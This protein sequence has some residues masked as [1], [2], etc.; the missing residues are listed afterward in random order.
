MRYLFPRAAGYSVA[1]SGN[2]VVVGASNDPSTNAAYVFAKP[3]SA[4]GDDIEVQRQA[5][6]GG[7]QHFRV[8]RGG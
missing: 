7:L 4:W 6:S 1:I 3:A 8:L 5:E 2:T